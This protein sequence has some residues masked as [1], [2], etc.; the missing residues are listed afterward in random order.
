MEVMQ[1]RRTL[2]RWTFCPEGLFR[3]PRHLK[4]SLEKLGKDWKNQKPKTGAVD[5]QKSEQRGRSGLGDRHSHRAECTRVEGKRK[6]KYFGGHTVSWYGKN[7]ARSRT[8]AYGRRARM[9]DNGVVYREY[10]QDRRQSMSITT[11]L[12]E[13]RQDSGR[14]E[15]RGRQE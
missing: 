7:K 13:T 6:I 14:E 2:S 5:S 8:M 3:T 12:R 9:T 1:R 15:A 4:A 10:G 11:T